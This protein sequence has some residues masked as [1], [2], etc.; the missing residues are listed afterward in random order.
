MECEPPDSEGKNRGSD[1]K[2]EGMYKVFEVWGW[3]I[4]IYKALCTCLS[5]LINV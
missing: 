5:W 1:E 3:Y 2:N 4:S